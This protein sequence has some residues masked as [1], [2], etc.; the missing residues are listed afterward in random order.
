MG[1][2]QVADYT[3]MRLGKVLRRWTWTDRQGTNRQG[4]EKIVKCPKCG[5]NARRA[6]ISGTLHFVHSEER[7]ALGGFSVRRNSVIC[8]MPASEEIKD[9]TPGHYCITSGCW[10]EQ[11]PDAE[12]MCSTHK[13]GPTGGEI[14]KALEDLI[15]THRL[16][17]EQFRE[18]RERLTRKLTKDTEEKADG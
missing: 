17:E 1:D 14:R 8:A 18:L 4:A 9:E 12:G 15:T 13:R 11:R 6:R 16:G 2:A 7:E 10:K 5:K 3:R